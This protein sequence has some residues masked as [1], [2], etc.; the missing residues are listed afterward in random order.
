MA[1]VSL[2]ILVIR[3]SSEAA[4][5]NTRRS[6]SCSCCLFV[7]ITERKFVTRQ[8]GTVLIVMAA[9]MVVQARVR[10]HLAGPRRLA[11]GPPLAE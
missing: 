3:T 10:A 7:N 1:I 5:I 8:L 9:A 2:V 4:A 11:S 6:A